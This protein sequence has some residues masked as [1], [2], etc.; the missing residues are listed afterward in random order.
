MI[1]QVLSF[2]A[3]SSLVSGCA[4]QIENKTTEKVVTPTSH[5]YIEVKPS[6][7]PEE[8]VKITQGWI[9]PDCV[10]HV[11]PDE[12]VQ[13][14][15]ITG[16]QGERAMPP[17]P[18]PR[19]DK[20]GHIVRPQEV[21]WAWYEWSGEVFSTPLS[22]IR[23]EWNVPY[24]EVT[25]QGYFPTPNP[26]FW[27][28][29][30]NPTEDR[31]IQS[32]LCYN[33]QIVSEDCCPGNNAAFGNF[34]DVSGGDTIVGR[35][36]GSD[37]DSG[38]CSSYTIY[39]LDATSGQESVLTTSPGMTFT[40]ALGAVF[41]IAELEVCAQLP[42]DGIIVF[43]DIEVENTNHKWPSLAGFVPHTDTTDSPSCDLSVG[44]SWNSSTL[45]E[46]VWLYWSN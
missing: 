29:M 46:S 40:R 23:G 21:Y 32:V 18:H 37:C 7:V 6:S 13:N 22:F 9:H 35:V 5:T 33:W 20:T 1:K 3:L 8:Y 16:P 41:E 26:S 28:G 27:T 4:Y 25:A 14:D 2:I 10:Y 19:F 44:Q 39:T 30:D 12:V 31:V 43:K 17:C 38:I 11:A 24:G 42:A 15:H 36:I 45:Q 34:V